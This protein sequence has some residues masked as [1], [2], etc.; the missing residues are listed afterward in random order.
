[1]S[2]PSQVGQKMKTTVFQR[3]NSNDKNECK[4]IDKVLKTMDWRWPG[5]SR[6]CFRYWVPSILECY[7][8]PFPGR[9][10]SCEASHPST[11]SVGC[12]VIS[13][14]PWPQELRTPP[15]GVAERTHISSSWLTSEAFWIIGSLMCVAFSLGQPQAPSPRHHEFHEERGFYLRTTAPNPVS[16]K[17]G[18]AE[19]HQGEELSAKVHQL[20]PLILR[21]QKDSPAVCPLFLS[22]TLSSSETSVSAVFQQ[23][24]VLAEASLVPKRRSKVVGG[25]KKCWLDRCGATSVAVLMCASLTGLTK[26]PVSSIT[27]HIFTCVCRW[28]MDFR[29][30]VEKIPIKQARKKNHHGSKVLLHEVPHMKV[31]LSMDSPAV[32][33]SW[34]WH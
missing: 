7:N 34:G 21:Y 15:S 27:S 12:G 4:V 8:S 33:S 28:M 11:W 30:K 17:G 10:S 20:L 14:G 32:L 24:T 5:H 18:A 29:G 19:L 13:W 31:W 1:M 9:S 2:S 6:C 16:L 25:S 23:D 3:N 22:V 26:D